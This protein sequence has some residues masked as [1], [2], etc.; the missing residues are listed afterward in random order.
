MHTHFYE[1]SL[2]QLHLLQKSDKFTSIP[3][4]VV[5]SAKKKEKKERKKM[6]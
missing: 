6:K 1:Q 3:Q 5:G 2:K 4:P